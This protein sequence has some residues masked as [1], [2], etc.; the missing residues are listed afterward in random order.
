MIVDSVNADLHHL[1]K[2]ASVLFEKGGKANQE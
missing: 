2:E 1:K